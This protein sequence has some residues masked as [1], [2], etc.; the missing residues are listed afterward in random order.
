MRALALPLAVGLATLLGTPLDSAA[1]Q[2]E[3]PE[4]RI[5]T[6][7]TF[8]VPLGQERQAFLEYVDTYIVPQNKEDP[9]ILAFRIGAHN[10]GGNKPN[11]WLITEYE[12]LSTLDQSDEWAATW[13]EQNFPEGSTAR[14][15]A[16]KAFE[17]A[18]APYFSK[19]TDNIIRVNMN[20]A[21]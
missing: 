8:Y 20:R 14:E 2:E 19:H 6:I 1:Q 10:W 16:D 3:Q 11:I 5:I 4:T 21:K 7:T 15:T 9:H 18:F 12:S 13:F 17:E